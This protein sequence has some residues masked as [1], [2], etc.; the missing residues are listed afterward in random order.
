MATNLTKL[1]VDA[2]TGKQ[3][4]AILLIALGTETAGKVTRY[5]S[6]DETELVTL[7]IAR[8]G[9]VSAS[10]AQAVLDE[11]Q[12]IREVHD[13]VA[14]G[15][16]DYARKVLEESLGPDRAQAILKRIE[17]ELQYSA[18][19]SNLRHADPQQLVSELRNEH[20]QTIALILAHVDAQLTA[21]VVSVLEPNLAGDV[22]YRMARM[23]KV[24]PD[25]MRVLETSFGN[26]SDL[27]F[28]SDM[29]VAGGPKAAAEVLNLL[30]SSLERGLLNGMAQRDPELADEIKDLMFVF[31]DILHLD[32]KA[33]Q[34]LVRD[35]DMKDFALALKAASDELK[36]KVLSVMSQRAK[37]AVLEEMEFLGAVRLRDAE[38]AQA[39]IVS[40]ARRLEERGE[41]VISKGQADAMFV[42]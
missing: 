29:S 4:A 5:L 3:K 34:R 28:Q 16:V 9:N 38:E 31:E 37:T 7:E 27:K 13:L 33:V 39:K 42:E 19:L 2:L 1:R 11:W 24:I 23:G 32:T 21:N 40:L 18:D 17:A 41:I 12:Q 6:E 15:G 22:I 36:D 30:G 10:V 35:I 20:P 14:E 25:V 8:L 26:D